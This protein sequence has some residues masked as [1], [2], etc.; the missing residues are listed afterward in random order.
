MPKSLSDND[1]LCL[2]KGLAEQLLYK[3]CIAECAKLGFSSTHVTRLP[4]T[5]FGSYVQICLP[6]YA[7]ISGYIPSPQT[8]ICIS[9]NYVPLSVIKDHSIPSEHLNPFSPER[10]TTYIL[11]STRQT[12]I[13]SR[14]REYQ[15]HMQKF[16]SVCGQEEQHLKLD[17]QFYTHN[18]LLKWSTAHPTVVSWLQG[19]YQSATKKSTGARAAKPS[20]VIFSHRLQRLS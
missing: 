19:V 7:K 18:T 4:E 8:L 15:S 20:N 1:I 13:E 12:L 11:A 10:E 2:P 17:S 6:P 5:R 9:A 16:V 14:I 3:L